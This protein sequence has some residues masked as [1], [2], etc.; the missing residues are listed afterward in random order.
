MIY[1]II[2]FLLGIFCFIIAIFAAT[3]FPPVTLIFGVVAGYCFLRTIFWPLADLVSGGMFYPDGKNKLPSLMFDKIQSMIV[4]QE[5]GEAMS[6]LEK[7]LAENPLNYTAVSMASGLY[8]KRFMAPEKA[9]ECI[10]NYLD[11]RKERSVDDVD[12]VLMFTDICIE[13][14]K[15]ALAAETLEAELARKYASADKRL[16]QLRLD[17]LKNASVSSARN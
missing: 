2:L 7:I 3:V 14:K 9:L 4:R 16:L 1:K 6:E 11:G 10:R 15:Y 12:M 17:A 8:M 5:Y 13:N